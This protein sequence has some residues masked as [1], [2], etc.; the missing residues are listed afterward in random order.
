MNCPCGCQYSD[1]FRTCGFNP[2]AEFTDK[3]SVDSTI[4]EA[5]AKQDPVQIG[6]F[7]YHMSRGGNVYRMLNDAYKASKGQVS[8]RNGSPMGLGVFSSGPL[9]SSPKANTPM[10]NL[11]RYLDKIGIRGSRKVQPTLEELL[12]A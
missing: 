7:T 12:S 6:I 4:L 3:A 2:D 5:L 8:P 11:H 10:K 1:R 9:E